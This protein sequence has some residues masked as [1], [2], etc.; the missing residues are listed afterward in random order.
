MKLATLPRYI[1]KDYQPSSLQAD[2]IITDDELYATQ[3]SGDQAHSKTV[4][5]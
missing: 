5:Q 3:D 2:V 4:H 1:T